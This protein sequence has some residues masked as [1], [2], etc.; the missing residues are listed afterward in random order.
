MRPW[1]HW[2][3]DI[4]LNA[5]HLDYAPPTCHVLTSSR[6]HVLTSHVSRLTSNVKCLTCQVK[7]PT[8]HLTSS[9]HIS[10]STSH[11]PRLTS[12]VSRLTSHVLRPTSHVSRPT[13]QIKRLTSHVKC[14]VPRPTS[15]SSPSSQFPAHHRGQQRT[16]SSL[17]H[18]I[19]EA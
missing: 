17:R 2:T 16:H 8:S 10:H 9:R 14:H 15:L 1:T 18:R 13:C 4:A 19:L 7:R 11:V 6:P 12:H 5:H 3:P